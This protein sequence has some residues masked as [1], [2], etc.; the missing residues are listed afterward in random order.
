MSYF[1]CTR[2]ALLPQ[3]QKQILRSLLHC[4]ST[5]HCMDPLL[6]DR[7]NV[8]FLLTIALCNSCLSSLECVCVCINQFALP[9][10]IECAPILTQEELALQLKSS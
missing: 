7:I 8:D 10:Q 3:G 2:Q 4:C 5:H 9:F 1:H 6:Q